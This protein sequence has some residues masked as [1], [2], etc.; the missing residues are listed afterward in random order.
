MCI[1][2]KY[3]Y[4]YRYLFVSG[5]VDFPRKPFIRVFFSSC[6]TYHIV[7]AWLSFETCFSPLFYF[8][9]VV[10]LCT[11]SSKTYVGFDYHNA[12]FFRSYF[13]SLPCC[14]FGYIH[15]SHV[16]YCSLCTGDS[17]IYQHFYWLSLHIHLTSLPCSISY[18]ISLYRAKPERT[19]K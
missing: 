8:S 18:R 6:F 4:I 1:K 16:P 5:F 9:S 12:S 11:H 19:H 7:I 10:F 14:S 13:R 3:I 17:I 15:P 2:K